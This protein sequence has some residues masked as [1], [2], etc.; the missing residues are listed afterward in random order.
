[1]TSGNAISGTGKSLFFTRVQYSTDT[2]RYSTVQYSTVQYNTVQRWYIAVSNHLNIVN[3][4]SHIIS[5]PSGLQVGDN[6]GTVVVSITGCCSLLTTGPEP[7]LSFHFKHLCIE[8][9]T[10]ARNIVLVQRF[11]FLLQTS[12]TIRGVQFLVVERVRGPIQ[13]GTA[14]TSCMRLDVSV[15]R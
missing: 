8:F 10:P 4:V 7:Q 5:S 15:T 14:S 1:V 13:L 3:K 6:E 2:V 12:H 9:S 11:D